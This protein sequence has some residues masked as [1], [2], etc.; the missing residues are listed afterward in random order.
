MK[1]KPHHP[2]LLLCSY[3]HT[4]ILSH[5]LHFGDLKATTTYYSISLFPYSLGLNDIPENCI[6]ILK[7][8]RQGL[9]V[10]SVAHVH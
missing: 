1:L 7:Q 4:F 8:S 6:A 5:M 9:N 2:A 10:A 3:S